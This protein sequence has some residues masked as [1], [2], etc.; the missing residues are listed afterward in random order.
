M[1]WI[2]IR[3]LLSSVWI[4]EAGTW[5]KINSV[6]GAMI[7][8]QVT[9]Q[10]RHAPRELYVKNVRAITQL[11]FIV[12]STKSKT[13]HQ[14]EMM[15]KREK[16]SCQI[17]AQKLQDLSN[18][19]IIQRT[20]MVSM[21][22]VP[23][24]GKHKNKRILRSLRIKSK[25]IWLNLPTIYTQNQLPVDTNEVATPKKLEKWKCLELILGEISENNNI[26]KINQLERRFRKDD[27]YYQYYKAF[28]D[29]M[30]AKKYAKKSAWP[31]PLGKTWYVPHHY[32]F[33]PNKLVAEKHEGCRKTQK[34]LA[35]PVVER[36][37]RQ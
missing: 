36:Q 6:L 28:M 1:I 9:I 30:L 37:W 10:Q 15:R 18:A 21:C 22:V 4:E 8:F 14:E 35:I 13:T 33:N 11:L 29:D 24:T 19:S 27:S 26:Q 31:A 3:N 17:D 2:I 5:Q 23:V 7:L 12:I 34:L 20:S 25:K 32:V 16:I